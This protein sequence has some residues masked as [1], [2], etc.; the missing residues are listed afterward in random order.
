MAEFIKN[1]TEYDAELAKGD[2]P[3]QVKIGGTTAKFMPNINASKWNNKCWLN[4]NHPDIVNAKIETFV[5]DKMELEIGNNIHRYYVDENGHL[6]YEIVL[7]SKPA[8]NKIEL[9]LDFPEG[10]RFT[11][12]DTLENEY[13]AG[14]T[15]GLSL[16]EYLIRSDRP[17]NVVGSYVGYWKNQDNQYKTGKFC[18]IYRPKAIDDNTNELWCNQNIIGKKWTIEIDQTWLNNAV[19]PVVVGPNLGYATEGGSLFANGTGSWSAIHDTTDGSGG[20]TAQLHM[21]CDNTGATDNFLICIYDDDA[22]N[23]RPEDQLLAEV[24]V[25]VAN[26][27]DGQKEVN[28]VTAVAASTKYWIAYLI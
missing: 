5:D 3:T 15:Q 10:L 2:T 25:E 11:F 16:S 12:Q 21:W 20:T 14:N 28:Y 7:K 24:A 19:Y 13:N 18:H 26:G 22:G 6:E 4:I 27:F 23:D 17:D 1:G 8:S 9:D